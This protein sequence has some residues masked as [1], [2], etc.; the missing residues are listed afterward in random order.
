MVQNPL[1]SSDTV[2]WTIQIFQDDDW[3][4]KEKMNLRHDQPQGDDRSRLV[5]EN[6]QYDSYSSIVLYNKMHVWIEGMILWIGFFKE[7]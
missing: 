3:R 4:R 6:F 1:S 5:H 2:H 7:L